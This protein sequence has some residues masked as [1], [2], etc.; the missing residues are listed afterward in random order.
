MWQRKNTAVLIA[1][2]NGE[3]TI[4]NTV[5]S[6]SSQADVYVISDG[7]TD[8]TAEVAQA[9][10]ARVIARTTGQGKPAAL[11]T[12]NRLFR[13]TDSYT[14]IGVLDDDTTIEPDY[15]AK[16]EAKMDADKRIAASSGRINSL[17]DNTRRWNALI[18]M[19]AF[20]YWSYQVT[21]KRGQNAFKVVNVIC[22]ANTLFRADVFAELIDIDVPYAIDDMYWLAEIVRRDLG[23]VEYVHNAQ[24]WTIDPHNFR[25]W[26]RQTVRWSWAQFQSV[27]GHHLGNPVQRDRGRKLGI[28]F[29]W[30]DTAY[31]A[32]LLDWLPYMLEP[33]LV[34]PVLFL[35]RRWID[36]LWLVG[37]YFL[38]SIAWIA[39]AAVA[40]RKWRLLVLS[41]AILFLDLVY[42]ITM[43]HACIK[44]VLEPTV[45]HC[46]WESP[47]RFELEADAP[48]ATS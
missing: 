17:W 9:A 42:R 34:I 31:L 14:Y 20:M 35:L 11:R 47:K 25:D 39:V 37:F 4:G 41:P 1:C 22:G 43:I 5:R 13:L 32:L 38:T 21:I 48:A 36:P 7:S 18:A 24:S 40:L 33:F 3:G 29:S 10:G 44:T 26:Y 8:R 28:R 19:R 30:F 27:R 23:R 12:G 6:A 45:E 16:I 46:A 2:K 15:V